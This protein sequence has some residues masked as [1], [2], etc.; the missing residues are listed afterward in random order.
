MATHPLP[1]SFGFSV[2]NK[3]FSLSCI[4]EHLES[5]GTITKTSVLM[6]DQPFT[7]PDVKP[8]MKNRWKQMKRTTTGMRLSTDM[9][10][11]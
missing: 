1:Q 8:A 2:K 3:N 5:R 7:L 11:T 10:N 4:K 9:A 6:E